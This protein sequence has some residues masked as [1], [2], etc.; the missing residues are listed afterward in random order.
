MKSKPKNT[1]RAVAREQ[2]TDEDLQRIRELRPDL[3]ARGF[4]P[5]TCGDVRARL[6][7]A[8]GTA[9]LAAIPENPQ[10]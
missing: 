3:A 1:P 6:V 8:F 9:D 7:I 2:S 4:D 5:E 10:I